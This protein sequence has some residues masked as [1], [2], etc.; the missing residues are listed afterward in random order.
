MWKHSTCMA[1]INPIRKSGQKLNLSTL[2]VDIEDT[3]F[4]SEYFILSEYNPKFTAGKNTFLLNGSP[5]IAF[6]SGIQLEVIDV[7]GNSL[8]VEFAKSNDIAYKEGGALRIAVYVY[9][10]TPFGTGKVIIVGRNTQN[11]VVRWVGNIQINPAVQNSSKVVFYKP[12]T[13]DIQSSVVP[14]VSDSTSGLS[15]FISGSIFTEALNPRKGDDYGSF[16]VSLQN[17]DYRMTV[18]DSSYFNSSSLKNTSLDIFV[19]TINDDNFNYLN[20]TSSNLVVD[21]VNDKTIKLKNP[22]YV[23]DNQNKKIIANVTSGS[24]RARTTNVNYYTGSLSGNTKQ[25]IAVIRYNN[26]RTFSGNVYRH[27]LYRRSL[28]FPG[29]F[30]IIADE[31]IID[32]QVLVDITTPNSFFRSLGTFPNDFHVSHYWFTSSNA[33]AIKRDGS[34]FMDAMSITAPSPYSTQE[35]IIV[36]N[37]TTSSSANN[38]YTPYNETSV[39]AESGQSYDSN[40]MRFYSDVPYKFSVRALVQKLDTTKNASVGFY[41]TSSML[42]EVSGDFD[43]D[44]QKG[45]KVGE[46][47]LNDNT[48]S[49][50]YTSPVNFYSKFT[51]DF[52]GTM[53]IYVNNC[54]TTLAD[55]NMSTYSEPSFSPEIFVTRIPFAVSVPGEQFEIKSELFDVN[56]NLV[57]S[58]LR[59]IATFD[60]SGSS[61]SRN[62]PGVTSSDITNGVTLFNLII[63]TNDVTQGITMTSASHFLFETTGSLSDSDTDAPFYIKRGTVSI[64]PQSIGGLGGKVYIRPSSLLDI[65]PTSVGTMDNVKIGQTTPEKGKFTDLEATVSVTIPTTTPP[66]VVSDTVTSTNV[67]AIGSPVN[68]TC[69]L[70]APDGWLLINGKKVP[71]YN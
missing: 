50:N 68:V 63:K 15:Q 33:I 14:V 34:Y 17:I 44:L 26:I 39:L 19:N 62:I 59:T 37:D 13:L 54:T 25:S 22:I 20:F 55:M 7:L 41:I 46:L 49:R 1:L 12:P 18:K 31:P 58:D 70:K 8:Y 47:V 66:A 40:F 51:N 35:Y 71:Y 65:T 9:N 28:Y 36:K 69:P 56:S 10:S 42:S 67:T 16:D 4:L 53:V 57:Y 61:L 11:K 21:V 2:K 24:F 45:I 38:V 43:F 60:V 29:D 27:K 23:F 5:K 48:S 32:S 6:N 3:S 30:E 52:F 64:S